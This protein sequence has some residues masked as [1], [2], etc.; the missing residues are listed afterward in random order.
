MP[1]QTTFIKVGQTTLPLKV[2]INRASKDNLLVTINGKS[3]VTL[4]EFSH[5]RLSSHQMSVL[6]NDTLRSELSK[7]LLESP[8]SELL[9][10]KQKVV[11][12]TKTK[13]KDKYT[14]NIPIKVILAVRIDNDM[15][16][17]S[18]FQY[19]SES[20]ID[21]PHLPVHQSRLLTRKGVMKKILIE[22]ED[23]FT[24][25]PTKTVEYKFSLNRVIGGLETIS[26][27]VN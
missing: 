20:G 11:Q 15:L 2:F 12:L 26:V 17:G 10:D 27:F 21:I 16:T 6:V 24:Q 18:E 22:D 13:A 5:A 4:R 23:E 25:E 3:Q 14:L 9:Q 7:A 19:L 8:L 1:P